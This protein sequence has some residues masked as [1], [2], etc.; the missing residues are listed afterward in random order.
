MPLAS[1]ANQ[2]Q[3]MARAAGLQRFNSPA[4]MGKLYEMITG[5][6]LSHATVSPEKRTLE[7]REP[8]VTYLGES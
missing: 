7:N 3:E 1:M 8:R 5:T 4:A 6:D 2:I